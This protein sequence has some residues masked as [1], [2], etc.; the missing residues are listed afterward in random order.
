MTAT[1][2]AS[3]GTSEAG[4][5]LALGEVSGAGGADGHRGRAFCPGMRDGEFFGMDAIGSG[6]FERVNAPID[7]ALHGG[8]AGN[9]AADFVCQFAQVVL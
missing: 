3:P 8:R 5:A 2:T 4:D 9:A 7:G 6:D 1:A